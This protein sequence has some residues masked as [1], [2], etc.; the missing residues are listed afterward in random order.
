[1]LENGLLSYINLDFQFLRLFLFCV[2]LG[3]LF[4]LNLSIIH[5][6]VWTRTKSQQLIFATLPAVG[7]VITSVISGNIALSLGMVG[8]L[9][10]VRFR[11]PIKN[12]YELVSYF[13]L[14]TVGIATSVNPTISINFFI[15]TI[16]ISLL[17]EGGNLIGERLGLNTSIN[18]LDEFTET[19]FLLLKTEKKFD[20]FVD[21]RFLRNFSF[22]ENEYTYNFSDNDITNLEK[23]LEQIN[24]SEIISYYFEKN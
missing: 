10:I 9:S 1:M 5:K 7:F 24:E 2:A 23:I 15:A 3:L 6:Q 19:N 21:S 22:S 18:E 17:I 20:E 16:L 11:S 12:P 13:Y 4:R 14:I 8:A